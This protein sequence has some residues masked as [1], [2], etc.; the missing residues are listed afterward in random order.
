MTIPAFNI[1]LYDEYV[2]PDRSRMIKL[3]SEIDKI[4]KEDCGLCGSL[5][6]D[7]LETLEIGHDQFK[8]KKCDKNHIMLKTYKP[9][10]PPHLHIVCNRCRKDF[11]CVEGFWTCNK[12]C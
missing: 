4:L 2:E 10:Y 8:D 7:M 5:L 6:L 3:L 11:K 1:D 9:K 12:G